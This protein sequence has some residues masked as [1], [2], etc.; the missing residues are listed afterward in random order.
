MFVL[1]QFPSSSLLFQS[2][3]SFL[4]NA[5]MIRLP[6][7]TLVLGR[8]DL[9]DFEIRRQHRKEVETGKL[10]EDFGRVAVGA[11]EGPNFSNNQF[12]QNT[13]QEGGDFKATFAQ[14]LTIQTVT[15]SRAHRRSSTSDSEDFQPS[16]NIQRSSSDDQGERPTLTEHEEELGYSSVPSPENALVESPRSPS[17]AKDDFY[18]GGFVESS[19][20]PASNH[21][22]NRSSPFGMF[23][24]SPL[25]DVSDLSYSPR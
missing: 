20:Q 25:G 1:L 24:T 17:S 7:T 19:I 23:L 12:R 13:G 21:I 2:S 22:P 8:R 3:Y 9:K 18:Y 11:P 4:G 10:T 5:D 15:P 14:P 16:T 6:P